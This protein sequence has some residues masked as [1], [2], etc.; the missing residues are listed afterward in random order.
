[1]TSK[2]GS[3]EPG[4]LVHDHGPTP[5]TGS[6]LKPC[7]VTK[8]YPA[9]NSGHRVSINGT[10]MVN[11]DS[12]SLWFVSNHREGVSQEQGGPGMR[13]PARRVRCTVLYA[14][15]DGLC[16]MHHKIRGPALVPDTNL[17][18]FGRPKDCLP[19]SRKLE[20]R[21]TL[22]TTICCSPTTTNCSVGNHQRR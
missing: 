13:G 14:A 15:H 22:L 5:P 20:S 3:F 12:L 7:P 1:M 2:K 16:I 9:I 17:F 19:L 4:L 21:N 10:P 18:R 6:L 8:L 11:G